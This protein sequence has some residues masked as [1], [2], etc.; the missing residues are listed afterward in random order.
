MNEIILTKGNS[1]VSEKCEFKCK[2]LLKLSTVSSY[3]SCVLNNVIGLRCD[4]NGIHG[5]FDAGG[6]SVSFTS[7][8]TETLKFI[9]MCSLSGKSSSSDLSSWMSVSC[10]CMKP[11]CIW[12]WH[13]FNPCGRPMPLSAFRAWYKTTQKSPQMVAF[14]FT[15]ILPSL[16]WYNLKW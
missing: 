14:K 15:W 16:A 7:I 10:S 4:F 2:C 11:V 13:T 12:N 9:G 6:R 5:Q 8:G 1:N 3:S